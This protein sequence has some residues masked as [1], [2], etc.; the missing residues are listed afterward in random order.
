MYCHADRRRPFVHNLE[1]FA[2][3][4]YRVGSVY[5][6]FCGLVALEEPST[7]PEASMALTAT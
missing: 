5:A 2:K 4:P 1:R 6:L 3:R 7:L